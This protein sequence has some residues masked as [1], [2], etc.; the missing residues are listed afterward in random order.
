MSL[1]RVADAMQAIPLCL[2]ADTSAGEAVGLLA[3]AT[4]DSVA[5]VV[6]ERGIYV[7]AITAKRLDQALREDELDARLEALSDPTPPLR[8]TQSLEDALTSLLRSERGLP[9]VAEGTNALVGWLT[10]TDVLHAYNA[11]RSRGEGGGGFH[12]RSRRLHAHVPPRPRPAAAAS[13]FV[14]RKR[15]SSS[16]NAAASCTRSARSAANASISRRSPSG[17]TRS[18]QDPGHP[19]R[20]DG[21]R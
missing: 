11:Q 3:Q 12:Y 6:D 9:V 4:A 5:G 19:P 17:V 21:A 14:A 10:H 7:G 1:L 8:A 18:S 16:S 13:P 2:T 15:T 20:R